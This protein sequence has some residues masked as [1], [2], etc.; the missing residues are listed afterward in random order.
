MIVVV[1]M[2]VV[3]GEGGEEV[4]EAEVGGEVEVEDVVVVEGLQIIERNEAGEE[5]EV[6][7]GNIQ[8]EKRY[9]RIE[10]R[11]MTD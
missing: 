1:E 10:R 8:N 6:D 11:T 3:E 5:E 9:G 4:E 2:A 7:E